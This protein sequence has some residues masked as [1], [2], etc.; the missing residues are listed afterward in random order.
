MQEL[1]RLRKYAQLMH[2][3]D[4]SSLESVSPEIL[5]VLHFRAFC[6]PLFQPWTLSGSC[7][8]PLLT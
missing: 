6:R 3:L 8:P 5:S 1:A 7:F 4:E 2:T